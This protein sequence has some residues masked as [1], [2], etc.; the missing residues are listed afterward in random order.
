MNYNQ[1]RT[2]IY[3]IVA[4][5]FAVL[6]GIIVGGIVQAVSNV[7]PVFDAIA[8]RTDTVNSILASIG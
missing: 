6:L 3:V 2:L 7:V 5:A 1:T 8:T 4:V